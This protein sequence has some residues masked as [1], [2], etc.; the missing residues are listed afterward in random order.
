MAIVTSGSAVAVGL[1]LFLVEP[2]NVYR[3]EISVQVKYGEKIIYEQHATHVATWAE[4]V[5][6]LASAF[7]TEVAETPV[8]TLLASMRE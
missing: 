5:A 1:D 4:V 2:A 8:V 7:T 3:A 6:W